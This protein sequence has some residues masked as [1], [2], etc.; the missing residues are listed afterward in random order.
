MEK[1]REK[2]GEQ[3]WALP[4]MRRGRLSKSLSIVRVPTS[5]IPPTKA[6]ADL[7]AAADPRAEGREPPVYDQ[8]TDRG[9]G[10]DQIH[11]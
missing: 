9:T 3:N 6:T 8:R 7:V 5:Q 1:E 10:G 4:V 2:Q 11:R